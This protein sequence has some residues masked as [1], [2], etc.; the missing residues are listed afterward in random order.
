MEVIKFGVVT[1]KL[2]VNWR[3]SK[4]KKENFGYHQKYANLFISKT[5]SGLAMQ[6]NIQQFRSIRAR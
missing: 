1:T 5:I 4:L 6:N 3:W 2:I